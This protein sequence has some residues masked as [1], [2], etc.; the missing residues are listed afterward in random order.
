[1]ALNGLAQKNKTVRKSSRMMIPEKKKYDIDESVYTK[2]YL[3]HD[4][5]LKAKSF[6]DEKMLR[7]KSSKSATK[8]IL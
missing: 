4:I 2:R 3:E 8:I 6:P 5:R 1:M 7:K